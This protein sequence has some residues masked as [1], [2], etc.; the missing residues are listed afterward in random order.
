MQWK[1][2]LVLATIALGILAPL[3][4]Q[5]VVLRDGHLVIGALDVCHSETPALSMN[6]DMPCMNRE[7]YC[8]VPSLSIAYTDILDLNFSLL[9]FPQQNDRPPE[10]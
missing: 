5:T 6:G 8:H 2:L 9:L 7:A 10:A 3:P 4:M 1:A